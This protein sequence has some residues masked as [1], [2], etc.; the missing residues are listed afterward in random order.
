MLIFHH[1]DDEVYWT[2]YNVG[3][4]TVAVKLQLYAFMTS[5]YVYCT[6]S[7]RMTS[8]RQSENIIVI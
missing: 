2:F 5:V 7:R 4:K 1:D 6:L 3:S 8:F